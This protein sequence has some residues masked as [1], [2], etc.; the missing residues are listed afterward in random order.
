MKRNDI[1]ITN[2]I[3][4][5]GQ[6]E[7]IEWMRTGQLFRYG[8]RNSNSISTSSAV[9]LCEQEICAYTG[10]KY[11]IGVNSCGSALLLLLKAT[12]LHHGQKVLFNAFTFGAVPSAIEHAGGTVRTTMYIPLKSF[13]TLP[14][15]L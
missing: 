4:V 14:R 6:Q 5:E 1:K 9:S 2:P 8:N 13:V 10:H 11:G 3:P 12:G 7:T 15:I